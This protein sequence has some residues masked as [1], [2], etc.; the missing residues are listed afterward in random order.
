VE[1]VHKEAPRIL[2]SQIEVGESSRSKPK[3]TTPPPP[4]PPP[5]T[6]FIPEW[7]REKKEEEEEEEK[8]RKKSLSSCGTR[9]VSLNTQKE[10]EFGESTP[11]SSGPVVCQFSKYIRIVPFSVLFMISVKRISIYEAS[12]LSFRTITDPARHKKN[13]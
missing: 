11:F 5:P 13:E 1:Q 3:V 2:K 7:I 6:F 10:L 12:I 9:Q 4:P 8:R